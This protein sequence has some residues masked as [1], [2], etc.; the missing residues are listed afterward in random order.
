MKATNMTRKIISIDDSDIAQE[1]IKISLA[2]F[3][4]EDIQSFLDPKEALDAISSG[5]TTADLILLDIMMPGIDGIELCARIRG[6]EKWSDIPIIMLTSRKDTDSLSQAFLAGAND[7]V[8]KPFDRIEL[9]ARIRSCLR[10]KGELD[11]RRAS[12]RRISSAANNPLTISRGTAPI[13]GL[14]IVS[15]RSSLQNALQALSQ[16]ELDRVGVVCFCIDQVNGPE[17]IQDDHKIAMI[18]AVGNALGQVSMPAGDLFGHW[19]EDIFCLI[20]LNL[21]ETQLLQAGRDRISVV[22]QAGVRLRLHSGS[23]AATISAGVVLPGTVSSLA[24]GVADAINAAIKASRSSKGLVIV[25]S[26]PDK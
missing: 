1:V 7:Y 13:P 5:S 16:G 22:S 10:L 26:K 6:L 20:S 23:G 18:K 17:D 21:D 14:S 11:R 4:F 3:G 24:G 8:T 2:E 12:D 25:H 19:D 9:Q 15:Q